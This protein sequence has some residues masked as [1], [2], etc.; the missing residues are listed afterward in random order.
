MD[1]A[2]TLLQFGAHSFEPAADPLL[3]DVVAGARRELSRPFPEI[4][5]SPGV[6]LGGVLR[7]AFDVLERA[8]EVVGLDVV[9]GER[10]EVIVERA[11]VRVLVRRRDTP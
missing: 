8:D 2:R 1:G 5:G 9:V 6:Y 4:D 3:R 11:V 10:L 7:G